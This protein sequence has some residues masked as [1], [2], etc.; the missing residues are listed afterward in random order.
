VRMPSILLYGNIGFDSRD[1]QRLCKIRFINFSTKTGERK[2]D[3]G[4]TPPDI[5]LKVVTAV[6]LYTIY[7][8]DTSL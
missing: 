1:V 3:R 6:K 2:T 5:I 7:P 4:K 8:F